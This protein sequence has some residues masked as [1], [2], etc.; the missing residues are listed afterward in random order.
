[1]WY[2]VVL[3][4]CQ[5]WRWLYIWAWSNK[6][7]MLFPSWIRKMNIVR[8]EQDAL[9][10]STRVLAVPD[11]HSFLSMWLRASI[12]Q[13]SGCVPSPPVEPLY[14]LGLFWAACCMS[15]ARLSWR[16]ISAYWA[17]CHFRSHFW[18]KVIG[19]HVTESFYLTSF[20]LCPITPCRATVRSGL[21]LS[22]LLHVRGPLELLLD[23][24]LIL[25]S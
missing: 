9:S 7:L 22:R 15:A 10:W 16:P 1:M 14:V 17:A 24:G 6:I 19:P 21:V 23:F 18:A 8:F 20:W 25:G 2:C 12:W 3:G 13:A 5:S 4:S 11:R